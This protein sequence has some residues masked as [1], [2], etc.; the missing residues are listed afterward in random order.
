MIGCWAHVRRKFVEALDENKKYASEA[1]VYIGKLYKIEEEMRDAGLTPEEIKERR[2]K[3][4]YPIIQE[5]EKWMDSVA[6]AFTPKS[7]MGKALVYT[8]TLLPRL[9]A[10]SWMVGTILTTTALRMQSALWLWDAKTS[11]LPAITMRLF[12]QPLSTPC[13][14]LASLPV[15]NRGNG[16]KTSWCACLPIM[17][18]SE[19]YFRATGRK[20][21]RLAASSIQLSE[22]GSNLPE[23]RKSCCHLHITPCHL[24]VLRRMLTV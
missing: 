19:R 8:Y 18:T 12:V 3:E 22:S 1:I 24:Y 10:M 4:S 16:W 15:L 17:A 20:S 2:Q 5:F 6:N 21:Q 9:A 11:C 23:L 13:S 7:R 14:H